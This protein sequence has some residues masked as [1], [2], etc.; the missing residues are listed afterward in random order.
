MNFVHCSRA[1]PFVDVQYLVHQ[2]SRLVEDNSWSNSQSRRAILTR[3]VSQCLEDMS[4]VV[5]L[6]DTSPKL[7]VLHSC[8]LGFSVSYLC[9]IS[10]FTFLSRF[11]LLC[12]R[13]VVHGRSQEFLQ[14]AIVYPSCS[15]TSLPSLSAFFSSLLSRHLHSA[16]PSPLCLS[17]S[18][19]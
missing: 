4:D 6:L 9:L 11:L 17:F 1:A 10:V 15:S 19:P 13:I 3:F 5:D 12:F 8:I 18:A 2:S 7:F 14:G 16:L